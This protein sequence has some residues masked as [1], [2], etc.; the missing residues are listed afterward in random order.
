M[1]VC[2]LPPNLSPH[3]LFLRRAQGGAQQQGDRK[4]LLGSPRGPASP[5]SRLWDPLRP[6]V[7]Q[8]AKWHL[9]LYDQSRK[10]KVPLLANSLGF[11]Q[12]LQYTDTTSEHLC[13]L[14]QVHMLKSCPPKMVVLVGGTLLG[15]DQVMR[16]VPS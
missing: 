1:V 12:C 16:K 5:R 13:A 2:L 14:L 10:P 7:L 11:P 9:L 15:G 6:V 3:W 8:H 4:A